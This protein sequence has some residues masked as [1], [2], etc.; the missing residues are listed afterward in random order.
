MVKL[1][2]SALYRTHAALAKAHRFCLAAGFPVN[3]LCWPIFGL[4]CCVFNILFGEHCLRMAAKRK[5]L[6]SG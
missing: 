2:Y 5:E 1:R 6:R 4:A 3:L